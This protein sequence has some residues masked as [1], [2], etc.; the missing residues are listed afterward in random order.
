[1]LQET[2]NT[3]NG[4]YSSVGDVGQEVGV[5]L[6]VSV[7]STRDILDTAGGVSDRIGAIIDTIRS[8]AQK[9]SIL[10]LNAKIQAEGA[11]EAGKGFVSVVEEIRDLS[12]QTEPATLEIEKQVS[13]IQT[14]NTQL[15]ESLEFQKSSRE[16]GGERVGGVD[17][18][19]DQLMEILQSVISEMQ[20]MSMRVAE[21]H[22]KFKKSF[23]EAEL[24]RDF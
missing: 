10:A 17:S 14:L 13:A 24:A 15:D 8:I 22:A 1:M 7:D 16:K 12:G 6:K 5:A 3:A 23:L 4:V 9:T 20:G 18:L 2:Q 21:T 11:G 19:I